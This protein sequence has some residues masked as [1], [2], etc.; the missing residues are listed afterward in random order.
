MSSL[1]DLFLFLFFLT[2]PVPFRQTS[3]PLT[4]SLSR[5]GIDTSVLAIAKT[6]QQRTNTH[7]HEQGD[8]NLALRVGNLLLSDVFVCVSIV[9][10]AE[11]LSST[12]HAAIWRL[13]RR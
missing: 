4:H 12:V 2:T 6:S 13:P 7:P 11:R 5:G 9:F 8:F 1:L 3:G 10:Y